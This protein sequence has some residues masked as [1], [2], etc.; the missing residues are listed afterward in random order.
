[1]ST[2]GVFTCP[3]AYG[4]SSRR[5]GDCVTLRLVSSPNDE[6]MP[7]LA[8]ERCGHES[9]S[10][11][12]PISRTTANPNVSSLDGRKRSCENGMRNSARQPPASRATATSHTASQPRSSFES[13]Y[14]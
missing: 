10:F 14:Q 4:T 7:E 6:T 12:R 13:P 2:G 5:F 9:V 8:F 1:G 3:T 11:N